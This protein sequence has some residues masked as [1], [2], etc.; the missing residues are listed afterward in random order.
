MYCVRP[1]KDADSLRRGYGPTCG[2]KHGKHFMSLKELLKR[3]VKNEL[4]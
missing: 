4:N 1:L 2:K 3:Y